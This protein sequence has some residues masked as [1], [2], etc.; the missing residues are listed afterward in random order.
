[1]ASTDVLDRLREERD[2]HRNTAIALTEAD[3][4]DPE[5]DALKLAEER[6]LKL[7]E[8]IKRLAAQLEQQ[9]IAD[10]LDARLAKAAKAQERD[11]QLAAA[12]RSNPYL[13]IQTRQSWGEQFIRSAEFT[14]YR[15]RGTS[16]ILEL[17]AGQ[18]QNRALPTGI[19]DLLAAGFDL[20]KTTVDVQPPP[21]PTPLL[22]NITRVQVTGNAIEYVSWSHTP[23]PGAQVVAEKAE[24]PSVEFSPQVTSDTL[25]TIA[26]YT[27][28]TRQLVEDAPAVRSL[29]DQELVRDVLREEEA[30]AAGA[31]A[32]ATLPSVTGE[33]LLAAI[34]VGIGTIQAE[35]YTPNAVLLNPADWAA[36]DVTVM[37]GTLLGPTRS[38]SFWGLTPIPSI[39][40]PAGTAIVG[41]FR[42]AIQ[43]F[44]RSAVG[45][46]VTDSHADTFIRNVFTILAERRSLT[47]VVRPQALVEV[48]GSTTTP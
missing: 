4:Y 14:D 9:E 18:I 10:T 40:Q 34:R 8:Q 16:G 43:Q 7:D 12:D 13:G 26:V 47:A 29:I 41:D 27:Q 33:D 5:S 20:G 46:Y 21:A 32:D 44:F 35:G 15:W 38:Q 19:T 42:S 28:L 17:D 6:A 2:K 37:G 48:S 25:D 23:D 24:K 36:L 39:D 1:M 30:Q 22:D 31:L 11:A 3:D 45:L